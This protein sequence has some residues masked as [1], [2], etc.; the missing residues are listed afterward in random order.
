MD[1]RPSGLRTV[2][3]WNDLNATLRTLQY[4]FAGIGR[5]PSGGD[6]TWGGMQDNGTGLLNPGAD[7]MVS[8][9]GG[10]GGAVLVDPNNA[11]R[12]V[13]EYVYLTMARTQNRGGTGGTA[14]CSPT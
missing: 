2:V 3:Q 14:R 6:A 1:S 12:A 4:Y 11:D 7:Q 8:P 9:F 5:T 13:N 10:D